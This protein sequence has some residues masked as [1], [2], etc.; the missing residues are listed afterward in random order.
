[1]LT[2]GASLDLRATACLRRTRV[3]CLGV[4]DS[5][6]LIMAQL[7]SLLTLDPLQ[8]STS[9]SKMHV[10]NHAETG[11]TRYPLDSEWGPPEESRWCK[12]F[13]TEPNRPTVMVKDYST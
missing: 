2:Y 6:H 11:I 13:A 10:S 12:M 4:Y 9:M 8:R 3:C 1:M 7:D 5:T